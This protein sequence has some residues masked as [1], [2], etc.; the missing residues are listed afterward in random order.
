MRKSSLLVIFLVVFIDLVG[1]GIVVPILPYYAESYGAS[2]W[3]LGWLMTAYSLFQ[4]FFAPFW[5]RVS[6]RVGRRP[7]LL[8]SILGSCISLVIL[9]FAKN[10]EWLFIG[11][12][13]AGICGANISTAY[14]YVTDVTTDENRAKGMGLIGAG[15]GL[16]FI[17][18]PA[19]GGVLSRWGYGVPMFA[20]AGLALFNFI[21][22]LFKLEEP[23]LPTEV[24]SSHRSKRFSLDTWRAAFSSPKSRIAILIFLLVTLAV[25]QMEVTFAI[26]LKARYGYDAES[27][28]MLLAIMGIVM[29]GVQGGLIGKLVKRFGE[30]KL[31]L[32]ATLL[33]AGALTVFGWTHSM[34][35][36]VMMLVFLALGQG[37]L[38][39]SLSSLASKGA[40]PD[41]RG[42][43]MGTFQSAGSLARVIGPPVAGWFYDHISLSSP[44]YCGAVVLVCACL[45]MH[46]WSRERSGEPGA[47]C[48][49]SPSDA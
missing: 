35:V 29:V 39:P 38:H 37:T 21:F 19:I 14:A 17:F 16:G 6:D 33:A 44:F 26:F 30:V 31:V 23:T 7:V 34:A 40:T 11:R 9:G 24:R 32:F 41:T 47:V 18:G 22:A 46:L 27:A 12:V 8:M 10:L 48:A 5:G 28:G 13:L 43:T 4:F 1:F 20:A 3:A 25:T 49:Q 45:C 36:L 2:A 15:F 42:A